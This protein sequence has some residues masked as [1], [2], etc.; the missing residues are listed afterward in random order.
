[1]PK[2]PAKDGGHT[3]FTDHRITRNTATTPAPDHQNTTSADIVA[4]H[5][6][7]GPL[8]IRNLG[9]ANVHV[10]ERYHS[11]VHLE[12]GAQQLTSAMKALPEDAVILTN[13]GVVLLR[14]GMASDAVEFFE[15][16]SRMDPAQAGYHI[17][18][19]AAYK[20]AGN[21][22]GA[23][24]ELE[25]SLTI[26]PS[27]AVAYNRLIDIFREKKDVAA[28]RRTLER[29]VAAA[30]GNIGARVALRLLK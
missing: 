3:A 8:A 24:A 19:A 20:E 16:A 6:P 5:D 10:G 11:A 14:Q 18:L 30:P 26:D 17:N 13:L 22:D 25:Q 28:L 29:Y 12:K 9:L 23:I 4:W 2:R 7:P 21:V 1:M 27:L 15:Y